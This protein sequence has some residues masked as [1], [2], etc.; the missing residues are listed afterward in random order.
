MA[1]YGRNSNRKSIEANEN[2]DYCPID[3]RGQNKG[4]RWTGVAEK[5]QFVRKVWAFCHYGGEANITA[6]SGQ[7]TELFDLTTA[8]S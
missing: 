2:P 5:I 4:T 3:S 8:S 6:P 1:V 7:L